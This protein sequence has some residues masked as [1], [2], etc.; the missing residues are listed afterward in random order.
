MPGVSRDTGIRP[1]IVSVGAPVIHHF[2]DVMHSAPSSVPLGSMWQG[3]TRL[4]V[5]RHGNPFRVRNP[6]RHSVNVFHNTVS[7]YAWLICNR[8][9]LWRQ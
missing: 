4:S 1:A 6:G 3:Q 9:T 5:P 8:E 2:F 7:M